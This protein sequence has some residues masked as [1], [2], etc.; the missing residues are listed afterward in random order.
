MSNEHHSAD[1][2]HFMKGMWDNMNFGL[3]GM[4]T[5]TLDTEELEK[6]ITDLKAVE[7]WL[8]MNLSMLQLT[9]QNLEM[10]KSTLTAV[11]TLNT[12][13]SPAADAAAQA[14]SQ[15]AMWPWSLMSQMQQHMAQHTP[16]PEEPAST[17]QEKPASASKRSR[18][19]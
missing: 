8:R 1:P 2:L 12:Q 17:T 9:I 5:P 19:S 3:P 16:P 6:R 18:K 14:F 7:G 15:A 13:A 4:I 10:Q 11:R